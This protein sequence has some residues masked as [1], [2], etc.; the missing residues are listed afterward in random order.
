MRSERPAAAS[1]PTASTPSA[2][3]AT[4]PAA[5]PATVRPAIVAAIVDALLVLAFVLI[6]RASHNEG[7]LGTLNTVW[8]FLAGLTI[9]WVFTLAWRS[10]RRIVWTGIGLWLGAAAGGL[11]LRM[12]VGQGVQPSFAIVTAV[13][14]GVFLLGWRGIALLVHRARSRR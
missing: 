9:G 4:T 13:V 14:L 1:T 2:P 12:V 7:L 11:L 3:T 5:G 6:G 8:P 10:P